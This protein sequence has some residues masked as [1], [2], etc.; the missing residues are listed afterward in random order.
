MIEPRIER[1]R[2]MIIPIHPIPKLN[3]FYQS[4][5]EAEPENFSSATTKSS[6]FTLC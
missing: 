5:K 1:T 4:L 6:T 2:K 3:K